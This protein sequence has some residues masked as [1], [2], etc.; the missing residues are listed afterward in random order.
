[1]SR[2]RIALSLAFAVAA[3]SAFAAAIPAASIVGRS[4]ASMLLRIPL[5]PQAME[6]RSSSALDAARVASYPAAGSGHVRV[7]IETTDRSAARTAIVAVGGRVERTWGG[8]VQ[9]AVPRGATEKLGRSPAVDLLRSPMHMQLDAVSGEEVAATL[10]PA[11]HAKGFTGKGVKVAIVDGGFVGLAERQAAGD[12]PANVVTQDLCGGRFATAD[13]HG[14]GVAEIVH[15]MAPDAQL[16]LVCIDT[17][18]DFANA[19]AYAK[20]QG[21]HVISHSASWFGPVRGDGT[22]FFGGLA[23]DARAAGILWVNSAGNYA[24]THWSGTFVSTDG[25]LWHNFAPNDEGNTF[26]A[27]NNATVCGFLRWDE[28]PAAVSDFDLALVDSATGE[29]VAASEDTQGAG[30]P[31]V[32]GLCA[33]QTSGANRTATWF[34]YAY[35]MRSSPRLELFTFSPPL[36]YQTAAGSILEPATSPATM[37]VGALCWQS[38]QAEVFTSQGP[39]VDGRMK[40]DIAGHD[41]VSNAT[42]GAFFGCGMSGF[43]GTSAA[44]PEVAGA[45]ALVKQAFPRYGPDQLQQYLV[46]AA[47]DAGAPGADNVTGAG[48]LQ[49]PTPP[50]V[51]KPSAKAIASAGK[52]GKVVKLLFEAAD[53]SGRVDV[54]DQVKRNGRIVK[55]LRRDG[56]RASSPKR[57]WVAWSAPAKPVGSYQHCVTAVDAG[58]NRSAA[59]CAEVSLR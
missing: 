29:I 8:L 36:Q 48:E 38:K 51:V 39:T 33:R 58:G 15:E 43:A 47:L 26:I 28:W 2:S 18:V 14:T 25:D 53:D 50:N 27:P 11:W 3:L 37:A 45:A 30:E 55:T 49:L 52:A 6:E 35:D 16:Y 9:A 46:Q 34:I 24:Q 20:G 4:P 32:E 57:F 13:D 19:V 54:I 22:G 7:V 21:V 23:A 10:A 42:F 41:S 5:A 12:L 17:E 31:A 44:A 40:P 56:L 1:M 59:S